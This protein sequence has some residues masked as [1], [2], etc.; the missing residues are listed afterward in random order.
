MHDAGGEFVIFEAEW[1]EQCVLM[2]VSNPSRR[3]WLS[4]NHEA[5]STNHAEWYD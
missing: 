1:A 3:D 2:H 4:L 5:R